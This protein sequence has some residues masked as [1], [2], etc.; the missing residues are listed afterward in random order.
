MKFTFSSLSFFDKFLINTTL[1]L[2]AVL[3]KSQETDS[4][5]LKE[6][7]KRCCKATKDAQRNKRRRS[8]TSETET[9]KSQVSDEFENRGELL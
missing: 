9:V 5:H 7:I 1:I 6:A 2:D 8:E 4:S 3:R